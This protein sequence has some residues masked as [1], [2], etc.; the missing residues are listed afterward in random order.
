MIEKLNAI[1]G[2]VNVS[3]DKKIIDDYTKDL[4]YVT[5]KVPIA[6]T[7]S[8]TSKQVEEILKLANEKG[9]KIVPVSSPQG[10]RV[11]GDTI[12]HAD[13]T[14]ILDLSKM[15]QI[16]RIDRTSREVMVEP[17]VTFAQLIPEVRKNGL[18]LL[19][20]LNPRSSKS[21]LTTALER[22]P[23]I[24]PRY[25]WDS[26]DPLC[27]TEVI[28]GTGDLFRTGSAAGP[29]SIEE[30]METG[31]LQKNPMGPTQF[32][33]YRILQGAQGSMGVVTWATLKCEFSPDIQKLKFLTSDGNLS[34]ILK[35]QH[36]L[37][38]YRLCDDLFILNNL[39]LAALLQTK[40][41][42]ILDLAGKLPKW[43]MIANQTGRGKVASDKIDYLEGDLKDIAREL[44][45]T[46]EDEIKGIENT[47]ILDLLTNC[48]EEPWRLRL[49]GC[50]DI[51][52]IAPSEKIQRFVDLVE[53]QVSLKLGV[54]IQPIVQGTSFHVEFDLYYDPATE[55]EKAKQE[56]MSVSKALMESGAFFNRPY[57]LWADDAYKYH[58]PETTVALN[59]VKGIFDPNHVLQPGVLCFKEH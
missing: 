8:T 43:I 20:P 33:P 12:P 37:V 10:P 15:N 32:S 44:G 26:S 13:N 46:L 14:I 59:K 36:Q 6:V 30:Q 52:F 45:I 2:S 9:F 27:C 25:Q 58:S 16:L 21:V 38:K 28:F 34:D 29:G 42:E 35:L 11:H 55:N 24:I 40:P 39:N 47:A 17:G 54:Y 3:T 31:G 53:K 41:E 1:C 19:M 49:K 4:S 51:F 56:F 5:G 50:Q 23:T 18:R 22:E 48:T 57:G 7:W